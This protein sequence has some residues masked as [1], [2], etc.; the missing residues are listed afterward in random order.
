MVTYNGSVEVVFS[1]ARMSVCFM[2]M[3]PRYAMSDELD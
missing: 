2:G 3:I 1:H